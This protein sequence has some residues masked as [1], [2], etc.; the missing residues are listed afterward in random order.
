[1]LEDG[2]PED[3]SAPRC[4]ATAVRLSAALLHR[5]R[6]ISAQLA[7]R[8]AATCEALRISR[9]RRCWHHEAR[10]RPAGPLGQQQRSHRQHSSGRLDAPRHF[11]VHAG[12]GAAAR[13]RAGCSSSGALHHAA[14]TGNFP[15]SARTRRAI[16]RP[17]RRSPSHRSSRAP[18]QNHEDGLRLAHVC[19]RADGHGQGHGRLV[20]LEI[21]R[22]DEAGEQMD[23]KVVPTASA[24]KP[25][26]PPI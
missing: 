4:V 5:S 1:M 15:R 21:N 3:S 16:P 12:L 23:G 6:F 8:V 24:A 20:L 17:K 25:R 22:E 10:D 11:V 9:G 2:W 26:E 18:P 19:H 14:R 13:R 7:C